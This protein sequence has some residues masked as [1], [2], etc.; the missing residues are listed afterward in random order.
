MKRNKFITLNKWTEQRLNK[1]VRRVSEELSARTFFN[2]WGLPA[3]VMEEASSVHRLW[4][5]LLNQ[6][7]GLGYNTFPERI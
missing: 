7:Y 1:N 2:S 5:T 6:G 3:G 4:Q